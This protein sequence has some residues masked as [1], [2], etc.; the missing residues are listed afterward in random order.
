MKVMIIEDDNLIQHQLKGLLKKVDERIFIKQT[1][2][3]KD[4]KKAFFS[5][6]PD[7][8]FLDLALYDEGLPMLLKTFKILKPSVKV[9]FMVNSPADQFKRA[10]LKIGADDFF[11][12]SNIEVLNLC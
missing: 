2:S 3:Y 10:C 6:S 9:I 1:F 12:K 5:F 8:V 4:A 11:D 7:S